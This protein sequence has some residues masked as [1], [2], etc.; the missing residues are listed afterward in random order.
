GSLGAHLLLQDG[1]YLTRFPEKKIFNAG[2]N[3]AIFFHGGFSG[4]GAD[5][6]LDVVVEA[7]IF[8]DFIGD[9]DFLW[10]V[11]IFAFNKFNAEG[12]VAIWEKFFEELEGVADVVG[13]GFGPNV[14]GAVFFG[15]AN[16]VNTRKLLFA[17]TDVHETFVVL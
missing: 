10:S 9:F 16:S 11:G 2:D 3:G 8:D 1:Y 4:T 14:A 13:L 5:A 7:G 15:V 17:Y 12:T 6:A